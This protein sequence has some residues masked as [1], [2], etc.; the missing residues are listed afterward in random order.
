MNLKEALVNALALIE[1]MPPT[2]KEIALNEIDLGEFAYK[3]TVARLEQAAD[4]STDHQANLLDLL[5]NLGVRGLVNEIA[6]ILESTSKRD[7]TL[8]YDIKGSPESAPVEPEDL[9]AA[10][11]VLRSDLW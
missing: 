9:E 7:E 1:A 8:P 5:N 2:A 3:Q 11:D 10:A 6:S 4:D